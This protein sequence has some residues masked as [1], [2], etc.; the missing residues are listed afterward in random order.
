MNYGV[1]ILL[2]A[3]AFNLPLQM[4]IG[5]RETFLEQTAGLR[6]VFAEAVLLFISLIIEWLFFVFA[7]S[8]LTLGFFKYFALI[9][10]GAALPHLIRAAARRV[11]PAFARRAALFE[12]PYRSGAN[13]AA[14]LVMISLAGSAG[15]ALA[16]A[17]GFSGG[18][19][20]AMIILRS[21][22]FRAGRERTSPLLRGLPLLLI[23]MGLLALAVSS[24]AIIFV[25]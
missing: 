13:I 19:F 7:L 10:L 4:G 17:A 2:S 25:R 3:L 20:F 22:Q 5:V 11:A 23:S 6:D 12:F 18:L 14:L 1:L 21:I 9:P 16:L 24:V 15:E 8:P